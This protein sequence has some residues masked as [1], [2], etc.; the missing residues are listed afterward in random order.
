MSLLAPLYLLGALAIA[1]P[2]LLHRRR[3]QPDKTTPFSTLLFLEPTP[4][5]SK[6]KTKIEHPLLLLLRCLAILLVALCFARP[7]FVNPDDQSTSR[8]RHLL[9]VDTSASMQRGDLP[10]VLQEELASVLGELE[11]Q[12]TEVALMSFDRETT[13]HATF[14]DTPDQLPLDAP[15]V[16]WN[17]TDLGLALH[18]AA[19]YIQQAPKSPDI[20]VEPGGTLHLFSDLQQGANLTALSDKPWPADIRIV[21]HPVEPTD[22]PGQ[23]ASIHPAP[24]HPD[25]PGEARIR[26]TNPPSS[27][28]SQFTLEWR[29]QNSEVRDQGAEE[30]PVTQLGTI[31]QIAPGDSRILPAP[32][33]PAAEATAL[34][35]AG[36]P[37][38]FDNQLHIAPPPA[39]PVNILHI[40]PEA[41]D[42]PKGTHYF[43]NKAFQ[44]TKSLI[45]HIASLTPDAVSPKLDLTPNHLIVAETPIP[46]GLLGL[47][48]DYYQ[49]GRTCFIL[50]RDKAHLPG[51]TTLLGL[52]AP[53]S[54]PEIPETDYHLFEGLDTSHP[55]LA[56]FQDP[57]FRDFSKL[58]VWKHRPWPIELGGAN[59]LAKFDNGLPALVHLPQ[60]MGSTLILT[61]SW[62]PEDSQL[63]LSTKFIPL[64]YSILEFSIGNL[65][66]EIHYTTDTPIDLA[67]F[68]GTSVITTPD[69]ETVTPAEGQTHFQPTQPGIHRLQAGEHTHTLAINLPPKESETQPMEEDDLLALVKSPSEDSESQTTVASPLPHIEAN[70][71]MWKWFLI[72]ALGI[73]VLETLLAARLTRTAE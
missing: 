50:L 12:N 36:D 68:P 48:D 6:T 46:E 9:L 41:D 49:T 71:K 43:L 52:P 66:P 8:Q 63:A 56:P 53:G 22:N 40:R 4:P 72:A 19:E 51:L 55:I 17:G 5:K 57:R 35:L 29:G 32:P 34:Q 37:H 3:Q 25:K 10:K 11:G 73:L 47:L 38:P 31:L 18:S 61:T 59:I 45:P 23:N 58:H 62:A 15:L 20:P 14:T 60:E 28:A 69:G 44:P 39:R 27:S 33:K 70:Q 1:I 65:Q 30:E 21:T 42:S 26:I 64:L 16:T 54:L 24:A 2:I 13:V 7:L 67:Q